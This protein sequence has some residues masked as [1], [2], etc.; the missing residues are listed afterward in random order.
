VLREVRGVIDKGNNGRAR[1]K[2]GAEPE[3][4]GLTESGGTVGS[5]EIELARD[6]A[7]TCDVLGRV[8]EPEGIWIGAT[9]CPEGDGLETAV[10][11]FR[12]VLEEVKVIVE[13]LVI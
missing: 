13:H 8:E 6:E 9:G 7:D 10:K 3:R 1:P 4:L 12:E 2:G 11:E 5:R